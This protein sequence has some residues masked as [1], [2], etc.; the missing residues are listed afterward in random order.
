MLNHDVMQSH[1]PLDPEERKLIDLID[2]LKEERLGLIDLLEE[3]VG[4]G[5]YLSAHYHNEAMKI[6]DKRIQALQNFR[7]RNF[8]KKQRLL[9]FAELLLS[10]TR[11]PRFSY[12]SEDI[13]K[14]IELNNTKVPVEQKHNLEMCIRQLANREIGGFKLVLDADDEFALH[15]TMKRDQVSVVIPGVKHLNHKGWIQDEKYQSF[16]AHGFRLADDEDQLI[17][18]LSGRSEDLVSGFMSLVIK[19]VF[20]IF[21]VDRF[22]KSYIEIAP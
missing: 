15:V 2:A 5:E 19:I 3:A 13:S 20:E 9:E 7:D 18:M 16:Y 11:G 14:L 17:A 12:L 1:K 21:Y 22:N 8:D 10:H 4:E 6:L